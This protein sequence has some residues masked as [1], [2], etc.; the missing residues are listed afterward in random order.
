MQ[1]QVKIFCCLALFSL[2]VSAT[3][4]KSVSQLDWS[5]LKSEK[6]EITD[7]SSAQGEVISSYMPYFNDIGSAFWRW[8]PK[9]G[10]E[11]EPKKGSIFKA[12]NTID[13]MMKNLFIE[14]DVLDTRHF[15]KVWFK[16]KNDLMFRGLFGIHDFSKPR[17]LIILRMGIHGNV[18]EFLAERFLAK[19]AYEDL[20]ANILILESLTSHAFLSKN[21]TVSFG[22][23]D[24]GIFTF[25]VLNELNNSP[26]K[27]IIQSYHLISI[28]MG[29]HGTFVT[30]ILD[31]ANGPKIKSIVNFCPLINLNETFALHAEQGLKQT[32]IDLWN[33]RRL[34]ALFRIYA[35][36][37][38]LK[39]WWE[40]IFDLKPR[41]TNSIMKILN[42]ERKQPLLTTMELSQLI[43]RMKWPPG[44]KKHLEESDSF[45]ELNNFWPHYRNIKIPMT[46]YTTPNDPLVPN[47][48][49]SEKIFSSQQPG[50]FKNL[51]F[52]RLEKGVHCGLAPVYSWDFLIQLLKNG[53][54]L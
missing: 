18:D 13:E 2:T 4:L 41:F 37:P 48:L 7:S 43:P 19:L 27:K 20:D 44:F 11:L 25:F 23:V 33:T 28:S 39:N 54:E 52:K 45:E 10:Q 9:S 12:L 34:S 8:N 6:I 32:A 26:L 24:E 53:L 50:E 35:D 1:S 47:E 46:I 29:A 42:D 15:R 49:N 30:A 21:N 22:G 14:F 16:P 5:A 38:E 51:K 3:N 36:R 31:Q 40:S 17:P